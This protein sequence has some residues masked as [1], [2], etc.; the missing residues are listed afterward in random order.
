MK[1]IISLFLAAI[2]LCSVVAGVNFNAFAASHTFVDG[3]CTDCG[4]YELNDG[5]TITAD[6]TY[7]TNNT[8]RTY[9]DEEFG[10]FK[11]YTVYFTPETTGLYEVKAPYDEEYG[12]WSLTD[13]NG[14]SVNKLYYSSYD[15]YNYA[16]YHTVLKAG[17]RYVL[18]SNYSRKGEQLSVSTCSGAIEEGIIDVEAGDFVSFSP[19]ADGYY[20]VYTCHKQGG[21]DPEYCFYDYYMYDEQLNEVSGVE[22][23]EL[24]YLP[25]TYPIQHAIT[26]YLE[27]DKQ[28]FLR[29][30]YPY[31][32]YWGTKPKAIYIVKTEH[33][34]HAFSDN[35]CRICGE[36]DW[37]NIPSVKLNELNEFGNGKNE[38]VQFTPDKDGVYFIRPYYVDCEWY[39]SPSVSV[40]IGNTA[41]R[42]YRYDCFYELEAGKTYIIS[43]YTSSYYK[44]FLSIKYFPLTEPTGFTATCDTSLIE[45]RNCYYTSQD[46]IY[47]R[48]NTSACE[49]G[50]WFT[51]TYSDG[52][53]NTYSYWEIS[54]VSPFDISFKDNQ[55]ADNVWSV[56]SDNN[57][58][59]VSYYDYYTCD[60]RYRT[61]VS[62]N[63]IEEPIQGISFV[64]AKQKVYTVGFDDYDK[65]YYEETGVYIYSRPKFE[66]GDKFVINYKD[67]SSD[68]Y[69]YS[70]QNN[71]S[72]DTEYGFVNSK[73]EFVDPDIISNQY[74]NPWTVG[75]ENYFTVSYLTFTT[76]VPVTVKENPVAGILFTPAKP[77]VLTEGDEDCC[78]FED[79][80]GHY[81]YYYSGFNTGD[82]MTVNYKDGSSDEYVRKAIQVY[83]EYDDEY[84][85]SYRFENSS[86]DVIYPYTDDNQYK[87]PWTAGGENH[88]Y[89]VWKGFKAE[90]SVTIEESPIAAIS[91]TP[92][93]PA[94][95][96]EGDSEYYRYDEDYDCYS[97][98]I[99]DFDE[100]DKLT[101]NYKD[102][103]EVEYVYSPVETFDEEEGCYTTYCRFVNASGDVIY[104][105]RSSDQRTTP[106]TKG[107]DNYYYVVWGGISAKVPV[108]II[109]NNVTGFSVIRDGNFTVVEK[110]DGYYDD[111]ELNDNYYWAFYY[112][113]SSIVDDSTSVQ[114]SYKD[115]SKKTFSYYKYENGYAKFI[116][117]DGAVIKVRCS[118]R[119]NTANC[120][121][122]GGQFDL[123]FTY[124]DKSVTKKVTVIK[125][126]VQSIEFVG[127]A[128]FAVTDGENMYYDCDYGED[129]DGTYW[130]RE[131]Y[132]NEIPDFREGDKVLVTYKNGKTDTLTYNGRC[133][134]NSSGRAEKVKRKDDQKTTPWEIGDNN[135]FIVDFR[136][137]YVNVPLTLVAGHVHSYDAVVTAPTCTEQGYTTYSCTGCEDSYIDDCTDALG[138]TEV[139][140]EAVAPTCTEAGLTEGKHCSVC[141]EIIVP[142]ETVEA[143]GHTPA[144]AVKENEIVSTY[145]NGASYDSVVYCSVCG[146]ELSRDTVANGGKLERIKINNATV[147]GIK[148]KV[149]NGKAFKQNITIKLNGV[150]LEEG[151]DY[152]VKYSKNKNVGTATVTIEGMGD[153][154]GKIVKTFTINP[155]GTKL[156]KLTAK[157]N[158]ITVNWTKI[159][160]QTTGYE[161]QC[162]TNSNFKKKT[163]TVTV[164][165]NSKTTTEIKGLKSGKK[166]Y[167]RL[168]V[169]KT[170]SGKKYYSK[171]STVKTVTTK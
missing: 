74:D 8:S 67:G 151:T 47:L 129:T 44:T 60:K 2:M 69:T 133:F 15:G 55:S 49:K 170:V 38:S 171:W 128:P 97:Y 22:S 4:K 83:D 66:L 98:S 157:K 145:D 77:I 108:S 135:Y 110:W 149:Y 39:N 24:K 76:L 102:G 161:I 156:G 107:G 36:Y 13:E 134:L 40:M 43:F 54:D 34:E 91:F 112:N 136:N 144:E 62:V 89:V 137:C 148:D 31:E 25:D 86:G 146:A 164:P 147:K 143:L 126:D 21:W 123:S 120:W 168:R 12:E 58:M 51:L 152:K 93:N 46:P 167:V 139:V 101:V 72:T 19:S 45:N 17:T 160:A 165:K 122:E 105:N 35:R 80:C 32:D 64:P 82:K 70:E 125:T 166:Y 158:S 14:N 119:Y 53:V 106:W 138:H 142:Q 124:M 37:D 6:K 18:S 57:L 100:G 23:T 56:G 28:Y 95:Y 130:E 7:I 141:G 132:L 30:S 159:I 162:S 113:E 52:T 59:T 11:C 94:V 75:G 131:Y 50:T 26:F 33:N 63:I 99:P 127:V 154:T 84:Y 118:S 81:I 10:R 140:D 9:Y 68:E 78:Y 41:L 73:G 85:E 153:Y 61:T 87:T 3:V 150:T 20:T 103:S 111:Y 65:D 1:K 155:K 115:G 109:E 169:Y 163:K 71:P 96:A 121:N 117:D 90:V 29:V 79:E 114:V 92:V 116:S 27:K 16:R 88:Y 5:D 42:R 104:P 48:Y